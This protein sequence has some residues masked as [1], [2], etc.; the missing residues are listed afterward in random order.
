MYACVIARACVCVLCVLCDRSR[1]ACV[2]SGSATA[3]RIINSVNEQSSVTLDKDALQVRA[4]KCAAE[5]VV[6]CAYD[7]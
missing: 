4:C 5:C 7:V 6:L 3:R 2:H 1:T